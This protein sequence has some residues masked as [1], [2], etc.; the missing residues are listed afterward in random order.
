VKWIVRTGDEQVA[1]ESDD[2]RVQVARKVTPQV[3]DRV[4]VL[5]EGVVSRV[6]GEEIEVADLRAV[7]V[8]EVRREDA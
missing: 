4:S 3:G 6:V 8:V 1:L 7:R 5:M 2:I